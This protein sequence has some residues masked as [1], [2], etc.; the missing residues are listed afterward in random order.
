MKSSMHCVA[1]ML[2]YGLGVLQAELA[3]DMNAGLSVAERR[4]LSELQPQ[5]EGLEQQLKD[6]K[7]AAGQVRHTDLNLLCGS[8]LA[9][10]RTEPP[11]LAHNLHTIHQNCQ[12]W[13]AF[14]VATILTYIY[15]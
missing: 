6:A 10:S 2:T 3:T 7:K 8:V 15:F 1:V 13:A 4:Q 9:A 5:I 14:A 12:A 11:F